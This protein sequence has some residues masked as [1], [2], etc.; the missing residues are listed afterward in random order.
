MKMIWTLLLFIL[1]AANIFL[2]LGTFWF[3]YGIWPISW[4]A[5]VLFSLLMYVQSEA[6][7]FIAKKLVTSYINGDCVSSMLKPR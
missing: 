3:V 4:W 1:M 7:K 6:A 5:F 2:Q